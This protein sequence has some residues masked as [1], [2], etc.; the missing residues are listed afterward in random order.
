M[1]RRVTAA[2]SDEASAIRFAWWTAFFAT[3]TLIAILGIAKSAQALSVPFAGPP[4]IVAAPAPPPDEE[5]EDEAEASEDEGFELEECEEDDE[6]EE[7][8]GLDAPQ[9]CL[10][11][12]AEA[13]VFATANKDQ[14]RLQVRYTTTSPTAVAVA[15]GLHGAKGSLYLGGEKKQFARQGVLRLSKSLSED[16]MAKVMAAKDFTVRLRV[17]EAPG[18]CK[19]FFDQQLNIKRA[20]PSGL[21]WQQSE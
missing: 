4:G 21:A 10:L 2:T 15:Y 5:S 11:S 6:C 16:Q 9:E 8:T 19:A 12:N 3:L 1:R 20:T 13:T 7:D 18:Y 14:V 17:P